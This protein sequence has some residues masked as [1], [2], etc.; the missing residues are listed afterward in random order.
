MSSTAPLRLIVDT[1]ALAANW[2]HLAA[3]SGVTCGAA[4]KADAYG[5]G[6]H[7]TVRAL[8]EAGCRDFFVAHWNEAAALGDLGDDVRVAVF[9]GIAPGEE[10]L[11]TG[12]AVP[13]LNTP[14]QVTRW[15]EIAAGRA[16]DIM[17][18]T[19]LNRLGL[20]LAEATS[21]LLDGIEIRTLHSHLACA[22]DRDHP[23]NALQLQRFREAVAAVPHQ[24]ASLA[25][26]A[27]TCLGPDYAFD[28][29]RPGI[30]LYGWVAYPDHARSLQR[31][32]GIE[33]S[34]VQ[35]RDVGVGQAFGYNATWTATR[36]T[37][38]ALANLGY[39]DGY[40]RAFSNLG[41]VRFGGQR[42]PVV[43][44]VSMDLIGV[45]VTGLD[46]AEGDWLEVDFDLDTAAG[47]TGIAQYE[48]LTGLGHRY[49]RRYI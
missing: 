9:H 25:N 21:G 22:D 49:Q 20:S 48:L 41:A 38:L 19:G 11:A 5:L 18:D 26:S 33:A 8:A 40:R 4:V 29:I 39:A 16:C 7:G 31:V 15:R 27:G 42:C 6:A 10:A 28:M 30:A 1:A 47:A 44:R 14:A 3:R 46:V 2:R 17:I 43:G 35:V 24:R 13:V 45:D 32:V 37:R 36:P 34:V 23:L 12:R